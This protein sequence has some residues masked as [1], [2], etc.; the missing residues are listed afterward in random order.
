MGFQFLVGRLRTSTDKSVP[1]ESRHE[2]IR[3]NG[4]FNS[5]LASLF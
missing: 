2:F 5:S 1:T 3:A 4:V